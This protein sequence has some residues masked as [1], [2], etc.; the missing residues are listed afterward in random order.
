M[1][2]AGEAS[3]FGECSQWD[4]LAFQIGKDLLESAKDLRI[5]P[6]SQT[7]LPRIWPILPRILPRILVFATVWYESTTCPVVPL[8]MIRI[9]PGNGKLDPTEFYGYESKS[10][11]PQVPYVI[12]GIHGCLFPQ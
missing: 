9:I 5:L 7:T 4:T 3:Q 10:L 1:D 6:S 8:I 12:A 2:Q 11:A